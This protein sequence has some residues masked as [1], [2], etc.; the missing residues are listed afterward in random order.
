MYIP[1]THSCKQEHYIF[2]TLLSS[3]HGGCVH[4]AVDVHK[5]LELQRVSSFRCGAHN[6]GLTNPIPEEQ[7]EASLKNK[8]ISH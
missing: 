7:E 8:K 3:E 4:M 5:A 6:P 1:N 2:P